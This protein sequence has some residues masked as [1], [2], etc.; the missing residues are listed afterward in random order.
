MTILY[1]DDD[2]DDRQIFEE[3][4]KSIDAHTVCVTAQDGLDA[5]S[6]LSMHQ[7]PDIIF[8][9][10]N[11]P[12]MDGKTCLSEIRGNRATGHLPVIIFTTSSNEKDRMDCENLGATDFL[13]KPVSFRHMREMLK[14]VFGCSPYSLTSHKTV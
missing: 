12:L 2:P 9:D 11:M 14:S 7:L 6:Y 13:L 1:V 8:L 3:A 10:L 5:L 4:V